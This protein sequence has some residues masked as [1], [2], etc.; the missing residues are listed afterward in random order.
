MFAIMSPPPP[1]TTVFISYARE[2]AAQMAWVNAFACRL[3]ADE[4][5]VTLDQWSVQP[6]DPLPSF[7]ETA[8]RESKFV[9]CICTPRYNNKVDSRQGGVGYEGS[10]MT[11]EVLLRGNNGKFIPVLRKGTPHDALPSWLEGSYYVDLRDDP[12]SESEYRLL[13]DALHERVPLPPAR[14]DGSAAPPQ[15]WGKVAAVLAL[16][17]FAH[18]WSAYHLGFGISQYGRLA[19]IV[20]AL[21]AA[22]MVLRWLAPGPWEA[23][24]ARARTIVWHLPRAVIG[25]GYLAFAL[26][27]GTCSSIRVTGID[28]G[29][30][31]RVRVRPADGTGGGHPG[32]FD[33]DIHGVRFALPTSP[34]GRQF[35]VEM[36]GG[37]R[38]VRLFPIT[39]V[40]L[41]ARGN[42]G[43]EP[44]ILLLPD[45]QIRGILAGGGRMVIR[46]RGRDTQLSDSGS[47]RLGPEVPIP[48]SAREHWADRLR[49]LEPGAREEVLSDW[50]SPRPA[51]LP[52]PLQP[53][54]TLWVYVFNAENVR[55]GHETHPV[56][57]GHQEIVIDFS[58][59]SPVDPE[60]E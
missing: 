25:A 56:V 3:H 23:G 51:S 16:V 6:G 45:P 34:L 27:V 60:V 18:L 19:P 11:A 50:G 30:A 22:L 37:P 13:V 46:H 4:V 31:A 40:R 15:P 52:Q 48:E 10:I 36:P 54:E 1:R 5:D 57:R 44:S 8:V 17:V 32:S 2:D 29:D 42:E 38:L 49:D 41:S 28:D 21:A 35:R 9:L 7:M 47:V 43:A 58:P 24:A 55:M 20:V 39:G 59:P 33:D 26:L 12:F 53:G 14:Q